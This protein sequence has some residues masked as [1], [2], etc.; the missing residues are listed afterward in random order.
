M[1]I[2][3]MLVQAMRGPGAMLNQP[4]NGPQPG[5]PQT[6]PGAPSPGPGPPQAPQP[7]QLPPAQSYGPDPSTAASIQ[8][9]MQM[10]ADDRR[11]NSIDRGLAGMAASFGPLETRNAIMQSYMPMDDRLGAMKQATLLQAAQTEQTE[12]AR[13]MAGA[14]ALGTNIGLK[15]GMATELGNLGVLPQV[16][17]ATVTPSPDL[18]QANEAAEAYAKAHPEATAQ[19][20]A[21]Y[22]TGILTNLVDPAQRAASIEIAKNVAEN[23]DPAA[24]NKADTQL[25]AVNQNLDWFKAHPNE[26]TEAVR[27][28]DW[29]LGKGEGVEGWIGRNTPFGTSAG[30]QEAKARLD[31]LTKQLSSE[32]LQNSGMSRMA[33]QEFM[34][35]GNSMT[36]LGSKAMPSGSIMPEIDRL[37][38]QSLRIR[39]NVMA[40]SGRTLPPEYSG[41]AD[42]KYFDKSSPYYSGA[43]VAKDAPPPGSQGSATAGSGPTVIRGP[44]DI[45]KL[46]HGAPFIIPSGPNK[47]KTGYAQ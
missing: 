38:D 16:A 47:G 1:S 44:E 39:A 46:P 27:D 12:H 41:Y 13:G 19:Q 21:E 28:A 25:A 5:S 4:L 34:T 45:A 6:A 14:E 18:K 33:M 2:G 31:Q 20:V 9:L 8:Q 26:T 11:A 42:P 17:G 29:R 10:H 30:A 3:D 36:S 7:Q 23:K 37:K 15:P 24:F 32:S 40:A 43:T 35:L 22:K